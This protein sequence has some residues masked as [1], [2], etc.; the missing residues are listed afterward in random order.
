MLSDLTAATYEMIRYNGRLCVR[1]ESKKDIKKKLGRSPDKGDACV[2][3]HYYTR[4][5]IAKKERGN[6]VPK[7]NVGY[8]N[9]KSRRH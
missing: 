4:K 7:A 5:A 3:G 2:I 1:K 6:K 9:R 8:A